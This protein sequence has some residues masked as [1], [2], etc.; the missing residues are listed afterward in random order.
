MLFVRKPRGFWHAMASVMGRRGG[1]VGRCTCGKGWRAL[2]F[3]C[4]YQPT[5][6]I[7]GRGVQGITCLCIAHVMRMDIWTCLSSTC[8]MDVLVDEQAVLGTCRK[9]TPRASHLT[10]RWT[11]V[12]STCLP[13]YPPELLFSRSC[14]P[15]HIRQ[16]QFTEFNLHDLSRVDASGWRVYAV[17]CRLVS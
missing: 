7:R 4:R 16:L 3:Q 14:A 13:A 17:F 10:T 8:A 12:K 2:A 6:N 11:R 1:S 9:I 15:T 5:L